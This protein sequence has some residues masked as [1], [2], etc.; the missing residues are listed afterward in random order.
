MIKLPNGPHHIRGMLFQPQ[1]AEKNIKRLK[2]ETRRVLPVA[3]LRCLEPTDEDDVKKILAQ[4]P[5]GQPG[6]WLYQRENFAIRDCDTSTGRIKVQ[7][8]S[9]PDEKVYFKPRKSFLMTLKKL[10]EKPKYRPSIH[11]PFELARCFLR[12]EE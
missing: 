2:T 10:H 7:F 8:E 4:C 11:M 12:I 6:D 5:Y 3:W 1:I 9:T